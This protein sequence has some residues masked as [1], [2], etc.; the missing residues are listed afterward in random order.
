MVRVG[1][2]T[3]LIAGTLLSA[4]PRPQQ[5]FHLPLTFERNQGQAPAQ[6]KWTARSSGYQ[7]LFN[8]E[9][10]TI[11]IPDETAFEAA[12]KRLPG[13]P[14]RLHIPYSAVRMKLAGSRPWNEI[15]G[16][17]PTGGVSNYV[18]TR[19]IKRSVNRIPQY[20]RMR[21]ANVYEGIDLMFYSSGDDLEYDFVIAP[22]ADPK[23]IQ[24]VFEG[25]KEVRVDPKSGD[26]ILKLPGGSELRQL[27]PKV[28]QQA[29]NKRVE[30]AGSYQLLDAQRAAFAVS[31]YDRSHA[32]VIDPRITIARSISGS[33]DTQAN[34]IAVDDNGHTFITGSTLALN[35][36]VTNNSQFETPHICGSFPFDPDFCGSNLESDVFVA[37]VSS[38]GSIAFV[39]YDGVGSGNGI[40][41]DSSGIYV[42]GEAIP[43]AGD[44]VVGFPFLNT[45][46]DLF[47][48][49]L[50]LTGQGIYFTIAGGP[51]EGFGVDEDLGNGIALDDLH[52]A[53]AVGVA[54]YSTLIATTPQ[55][56]V[57]LVEIAPDGTKLVQRGFSSTKNDAGMAVAVAGRQPWITGQ[58]CGDS[59]STTDGV[60]HHLDHCAVFVIHTDEAGNPQMGMIVGGLNADDAGT[61]IVMNGGNTAFVTGYINSADFPHSTNGL[62]SVPDAPRPW[63]FVFEVT[64]TNVSLPP[65][66][67]QLVG[68]IVRSGLINAPSG[69]VK[70]YAIANDNRGG[71][72]VAGATSS[73]S[74][75][76]ATSPGLSG[77][78]NGFIAKISADLSQIDYS[79]LLGRTLTGVALRGP[80]SVFPPEA[81][82]A[83]CFPEIY[84]AGWDDSTFNDPGSPREA[85]MVKMVDDTP[86]SFVTN[87]AAEV[88]TNPFTVS[89]GGSAP[90]S[91]VA[92]FDVFVSDNGASFIPF[93]T[94]TT[95]TSAPFTGVPGHTYGFFS[96]AT[97]ASGIKEPMKTKADVVTKIADITP[98]IITPQITGVPG[99]NG[100]Y[101]SAVTVSW[102]VT[103][104]ESGITSSMGCAPTN[105]TA[106]TAGLTLTCSATNGVGISTSVPIT[107][108]IDKT[109]P[110]ISGMPALHCSLSPLNPKLV[111]V[112]TVTATD[113]V[114]GLAAGSFSVSVTSNNPSSGSNPPAVAIIPNGSGGFTVL[115]ADRLASGNG[116]AFALTAIAIDN[117][118]NS[119]T[120]I[121]TCA[122][123]Q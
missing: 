97:D 119:A 66:P 9:S 114:S 3:C 57:I 103:D 59:F 12:S 48:Q 121:A 11:V 20:R 80:L 14:P 31:G 117:A 33:K 111:Q 79:V 19:D 64:S 7:V 51:G 56:H 34:A 28:Y 68:T 27:K 81:S 50:S 108:K 61:G 105:L 36:P 123:S 87:T 18:N 110:L 2:L 37:E 90:L 54:T 42:T 26:L 55:R 73:P 89:W 92:S 96:I 88:N 115:G 10:A 91:S 16:A 43:P 95:A 63:G 1:V 46:G 75:P 44:I 94:G 109:A 49:R 21:V 40:A 41:V 25:T 107:I 62:L 84:V 100:W 99:S 72:Y 6:V 120:A 17:E 35:L 104:P 122:P 78:P 116:R 52:N 83:Q 13:T 60:M 8:D 74:F 113:A 29:G 98:P 47:V 106:D 15:S 24:V 85:F 70:P 77:S 76:R 112:A 39:T 93:V 30:I 69:F 102:S 65:A 118:G 38:D 82:C 32:L 58:T 45:A 86:T 71:L 22:G 53:W 5:P 23:Q 67:P 4:P 101:R